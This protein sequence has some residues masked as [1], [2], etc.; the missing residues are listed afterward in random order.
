MSPHGTAVERNPVGIIADRQQSGST[1]SE[2]V[3]KPT[4]KSLVTTAKPVDNASY[5]KG[6]EA[7]DW[8]ME[9]RLRSKSKHSSGG[10]ILNGNKFTT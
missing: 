7:L 1:P 2:K 3:T 10:W 6:T 8:Y 4:E 9:R 5:S